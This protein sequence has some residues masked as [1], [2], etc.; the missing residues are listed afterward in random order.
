MKK[1]VE[2][3]EPE[4]KNERREKMLAELAA[5]A[6]VVFAVYIGYKSYVRYKAEGAKKEKT[7]RE[8][9]DVWFQKKIEEIEKREYPKF[10]SYKLYVQSEIQ[11]LPHNIIKKLEEKYGLR[12]DIPALD[13]GELKYDPEFQKSLKKR[14]EKEPEI[15]NKFPSTGSI[16]LDYKFFLSK[17]AEVEAIK[18][19]DETIKGEAIETE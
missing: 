13:L 7:T 5:V 11:G 19:I 2:S 10:L 17:K 15:M 12:T 4:K 14:M 18:I 3:K 16:P 8:D 6:V 9:K 1:S